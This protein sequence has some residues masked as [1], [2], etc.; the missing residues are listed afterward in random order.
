MEANGTEEGEYI[1]LWL[2]VLHGAVGSTLLLCSIFCS[3]SV[4]LL[5]LCNKTLRY[6]S[7]VA[8][9]GLIVADL[10]LAVAW[11]FQVLELSAVGEWTLGDE[12]CTF[13]GVILVWLLYVRWSEVTVVTADRFLIVIF[14]FFTYQRCSKPLLITMS[15]LAWLVPAAL[16]IPSIH[17]FG[18]YNFRLQ[19]SSCTVDCE[20]DAPCTAFYTSLFGL[21]LLVGGVLPAVMYTAMYCTGLRKRWKYKNRQLGTVASD[22]VAN[23]QE[24]S[25]S[26]NDVVGAIDTNV[27]SSNG[28]VVQPQRAV[29]SSSDDAANDQSGQGES[30]S[31]RRRLAKFRIKPRERRALV[32]IFIIF[33]SMLVTH[34]PTYVISSI[35]SVGNVYE[36]T[37]LIVHYICVYVFLLGPIFDS[38]IIMRNRDFRD[39]I[40]KLFKRRAR[41]AVRYHSDR[42]PSIVLLLSGRRN[43]LTPQINESFKKDGCDGRVDLQTRA[44]WQTRLDTID[45]TGPTSHTIDL[46]KQVSIDDS[47]Y[48][49][50]TEV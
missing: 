45:E 50:V 2:R 28:D 47:S 43:S 17:G 44:P 4:L 29:T 16:V 37:P 20:G 48:K 39:V 7:T 46:E 24:R 49:Y 18:T 5:V 41:P 35:R 12:A 11:L 15:I 25:S 36:S 13:F 26:D 33:I 3:S 21:Y 8:S 14:P 10:V 32:T 23:T 22:S 38:I 30:K 42:R 34:I 1:E 27:S 6:P 31:T 19:I 40:R 9:L